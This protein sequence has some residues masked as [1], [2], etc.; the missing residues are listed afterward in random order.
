MGDFKFREIDWI[1]VSTTNSHEQISTKFYELCK[2]NYLE[3]HETKP[4]TRCRGS[5]TP[6]ILDL[7]FTD[8]TSM[9]DTIEHN[10]SL[11]NSDYD[12]LEFEVR[13]LKSNNPRVFYKIC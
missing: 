12:V 1:S 2:D 7:I 9:I 13:I 3:Q 11:G 5:D 10:A 8:E 6:S 4:T